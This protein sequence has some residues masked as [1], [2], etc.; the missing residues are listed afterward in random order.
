MFYILIYNLYIQKYFQYIWN[1][2]GIYKSVA[3]MLTGR[4]KVLNYI[5]NH[6]LIEKICEPINK[7]HIPV[8]I[9]PRES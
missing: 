3:N 1:V 5:L 9:R 7:V 2:F 6:T 8:M 4:A